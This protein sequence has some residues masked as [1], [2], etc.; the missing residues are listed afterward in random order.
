MFS[1]CCVRSALY[2]GDVGGSKGGVELPVIAWWRAWTGLMWLGY[3]AVAG[4][5]HG[6]T[7]HLDTIKSFFYLSN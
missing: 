4:F 6:C 7:I 5:F 3:N 1:L 2:H